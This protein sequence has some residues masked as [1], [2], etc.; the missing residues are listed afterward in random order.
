MDT[1]KPLSIAIAGG[2]IG[3]LCLAIGLLSQP[4]LK[5]SIYEAA[6]AFSEI[7]AGLNIGPNSQRALALISPQAEEAFIN[8]RTSNGSPELKKAFCEYRYGRK[9]EREGEL[10]GVVENETGAQSVHRARFLDEL[11][12]C[13]P[14]GMAQFGKRLTHVEELGPDEGIILRFADGSTAKADCLLGADGIHSATRQHILGATHPAAKPVFTG[15]V[16]HRGLIPMEKARESIGRFADDMRAWCGEGGMVMTYP[17]DFGDTLNVAAI[18]D[19]ISSWDYPQFVVPVDGDECRRQYP[20]WG[21][22]PMKIL[23]L[24]EKPNKWAMLHHLPA[25]R[26]NSG[27]IAIMGDAAHASTPYQGAGVSQ[28]IEDALVLSTL[29]QHVKAIRDIAPALSAYDAVRR[30]RSQKVVETSRE[31]MGLYSFSDDFVKGDRELWM[32]AWE[33]RMDWIWDVDLV[34]QNEEAVKLFRDVVENGS[35]AVNTVGEDKSR[36]MES[37]SG[38]S[39]RLEASGRGSRL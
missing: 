37:S 38:G 6:P 10:L 30:P 11:V 12:K 13:I 36:S 20:D 27:R 2:G 7:G 5:I 23:N 21:D 34:K 28:A 25:P 33:G 24:L 9:G 22:I 39:L 26:Y 8:Q 31:T 18:R 19:G 35:T 4:H 32:K 14:E 17:I 29:F 15:T 3:G 16:S 1:T